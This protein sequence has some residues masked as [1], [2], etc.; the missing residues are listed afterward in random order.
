[1]QLLLVRHGN[2]F[3]PGDKIIRVGSQNDLPLVEKGEAQARDVAR[4]IKDNQIQA[5]VIFCSSL[6]RTKSFAQIIIDQLNLKFS[7]VIDDCLSELDYGDWSGLTNEEIIEQFGEEEFNAWEE[8]SQMPEKANWGS[9]E[10]ETI[11]NINTFIEKLENDFQGDETIIVV[12]SNGLLRYFLKLIPGEF[13][14]RITNN[15]FKMKTSHISKLI[16]DNN[17]WHTE[18]WNNSPLQG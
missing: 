13:E 10:T 14:K 6:Q 16:Y 2:T 3:G 1:M 9:S 7:P 5:K 11:Q 17:Q 4:F 15:T 12:S 18:F 8:K